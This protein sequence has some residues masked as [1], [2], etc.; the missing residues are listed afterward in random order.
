MNIQ[1]YK[2]LKGTSFDL[3]KRVNQNLKAGFVL[4]GAP[5][6]TGKKLPDDYGATE[7]AQAVIFSGTEEEIRK[8][9]EY[10]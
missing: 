8:I 3:E 6:V 1:Y 9:T 4:H 5:F 7:F 2:L 10:A